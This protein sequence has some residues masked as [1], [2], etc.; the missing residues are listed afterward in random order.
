MVT[1]TVPQPSGSFLSVIDAMLFIF[2]MATIQHFANIHDTKLILMPN[3]WLGRA[4]L[5]RKLSNILFAVYE[6]FYNIAGSRV[7]LEKW[8]TTEQELCPLKK[9]NFQ[10]LITLCLN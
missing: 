1:I 5:L 9:L 3:H 8:Y 6:K 10:A 4:Y 2:K 7:M